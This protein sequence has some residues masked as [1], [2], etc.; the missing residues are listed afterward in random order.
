MPKLKTRRSAQKRYKKTAQG[1]FIRKIAFKGHLLAKKSST[2]KRRLSNHVL[3]HDAEFFAVKKM[4]P[5]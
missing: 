3:V 1:K 5:Y 2:R 4:L